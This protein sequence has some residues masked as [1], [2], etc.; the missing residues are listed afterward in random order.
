MSNKNNPYVISANVIILLFMDAV[1]L[2]FSFFFKHFKISGAVGFL[3][4][5]SRLTLHNN[6]ELAN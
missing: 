3:Y 5:T 2:L 4:Y 1:C 6:I